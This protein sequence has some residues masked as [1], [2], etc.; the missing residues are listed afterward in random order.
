MRQKFNKCKRVVVKVGSNILT[1]SSGA[2]NLDF[3]NRLVKQI[4]YLSNQGQDL[5]LVT[6]G[7]IRCGQEKLAC[8]DNS[9]I[10]PSS[11]KVRSIPQK[12]AAAAIGQSLL[13][14]TY[15]KY[16]NKYG[17]L[18]G[19]I[20]LTRDDV[21]DR[22][23]FLNAR[24]T[25]LALFKYGAIP[26]VNEND[27]VG[28]EEIIEMKFGDNDTLSALVSSLVEAELLII[29]SDVEGMMTSDPHQDKKAKL[30][31]EVK[32]IDE[33][34]QKIAGD[35]GSKG[36]VGGMRVKLQAAKIAAYSGVSTVIASGTHRNVLIDIEE[37]KDIGTLFLPKSKKL[38]S[39]KCWIAFCLPRKG[40]I[41][42]NEGAK[43]MII[44]QGKSLLPSGIIS[45]EGRFNKGEA[46]TLGD[47]KDREFAVGLVNYSL[48]EVHLIKGMHSGEIKK[49]LGFCEK[50]EV[51]HRDNLAI[52]V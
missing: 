32:E 18:T 17:K 19:Q 5:V 44:N 15:N 25:F 28:V 3:I 11:Y 52:L 40:N 37:G 4:V 50:E 51:I 41:K 42:V 38:S 48:Q 12:Q 8:R 49:I 31:S 13:M 39:R 21:A 29:L 34:L 33:N 47:E 27:S 22:R 1:T 43:H 6:S 14:Q 24:N 7:A 30:I 46:V 10:A 35:K 23:R 9:R 36:S 16:F 45:A 26:I 20:L 2:I